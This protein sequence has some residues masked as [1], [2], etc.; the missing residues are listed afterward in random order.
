MPLP[1]LSGT[2]HQL[3]LCQ[4]AAGEHLEGVMALSLVIRW[5]CS[6]ERWH[7]AL[8]G[9]GRR[10]SKAKAAPD[11]SFS[12]RAFSWE[13]EGGLRWLQV[14]SPH[15]SAAHAAFRGFHN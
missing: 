14:P 3:Q 7:T 13:D 10:G 1:R 9:A 2:A 6:R 12:P 8:Q 4:R 15:P 11:A 5:P